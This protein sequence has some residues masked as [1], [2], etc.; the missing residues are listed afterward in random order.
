MTKDYIFYHSVEYFSQDKLSLET[1]N[2]N[3]TTH[4]SQK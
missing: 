4:P 1:K 3:T 2:K